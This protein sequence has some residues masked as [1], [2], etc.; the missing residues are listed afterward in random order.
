MF[1]ME[2]MGQ[3][4]TATNRVD[5][6]SKRVDRPKGR[7]VHSGAQRWVV[8]CV[9]A[10]SRGVVVK[11]REAGVGQQATRFNRSSVRLLASSSLLLRPHRIVNLCRFRNLLSRSPHLQ[12]SRPRYN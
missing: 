2:V 10:A 1:E 11:A 7:A 6:A 5:D 12:E 9:A 4:L 3:K 8:C